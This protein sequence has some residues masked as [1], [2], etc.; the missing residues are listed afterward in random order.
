MVAPNCFDEAPQNAMPGLD[1]AVT[2]MLKH[3]WM[4]YGAA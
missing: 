4:H 1:V 2:N 3:H